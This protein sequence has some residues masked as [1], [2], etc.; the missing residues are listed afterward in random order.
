MDHTQ[1]GLRELMLEVTFS[2]PPCS[3]YF[4]AIPKERIRRNSE[5]CFLQQEAF[6]KSWFFTDGDFV[7]ADDMMCKC[8]SCLGIAP[9]ASVTIHFLIIII[10]VD[11]DLAFLSTYQILS[12]DL[13]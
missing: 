1:I 12:K 11:L 7:N 2:N 5:F 9:K 8:S 13:R 3:K 4:Y 10:M 6:T